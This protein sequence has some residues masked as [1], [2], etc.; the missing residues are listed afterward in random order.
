MK[1]NRNG[2]NLPD[3]K[4]GTHFQHVDSFEIFRL[5]VK[6]AQLSKKCS[7][8]RSACLSKSKLQGTKQN[9]K[10]DGPD[11]ITRV[12]K[13][14]F[15][16]SFGGPFSAV[17]EKRASMKNEKRASMKYRYQEPGALKKKHSPVLCSLFF[18]LYPS[19]YHRTTNPHARPPSSGI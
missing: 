9:L 2:K 17:S 1:N 12:Y 13:E 8:R 10:I 18:R 3:G 14:R 11:D 6:A 4:G 5:P 16:V 19:F 7:R 15:F